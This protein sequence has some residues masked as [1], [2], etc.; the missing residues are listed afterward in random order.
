VKRHI[1]IP[2]TQVRKGVP[3][4]HILAAAR[5]VVDY[6]PD[7]LIV[8]GDWWDFP[9]LNSHSEK[10]SAELENTR[11]QDDLDAGNEA[12]LRL[13]QPMEA[14]QA[15][16]VKNKEKQWKP[17]KVFTRGNHE[18]RSDR[19]AQNDPKWQGV[20]GS[21]N[22][23]TRDFEVYPFLEIVDV[24]GIAYSHYF[25]NTHSGRP[26]GGTIPNR[27]S[28]IGRSFACGHEQGMQYGMQQY[29]GSI[30]RHGLVAG[31]FY[32]HCE[33]YRGAQGRDEWR[34]IVVLNEVVDG[35]YCVMPLTMNYLRDKYA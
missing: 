18:H 33:G 11:Y 28:K 24:D 35:D 21:H 4:D 23:H 12:F 14:E 30:R 7:E 26:I 27:L 2:D 16:L 10:G 3:T 17:R 9:S 31:S 5:A 34:G 22:C 15:R 25:A 20:I 29:P 6:K 8:G 1:W 19:V 13:C 32:Q